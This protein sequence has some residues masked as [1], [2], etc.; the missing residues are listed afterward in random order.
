ML[1]NRIILE[2]DIL[3]YNFYEFDFQ[4]MQNNKNE[5][6]IKIRIEFYLCVRNIF[7]TLCYFV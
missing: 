4:Y 6:N 2:K 7:G 5:L 3:F 1:L